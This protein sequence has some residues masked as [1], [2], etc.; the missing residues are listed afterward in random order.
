MKKMNA[1]RILALLLTLAMLVA[2]AACSGNSGSGTPTTTTTTDSSQQSS[3]TS[4]TTDT[5]PVVE[6]TEPEAPPRDLGG[7]NIRLSDWWT[8][9]DAEETPATTLRDELTREYRKSIQETHNFT[10][11]QMS[12]GGWGEYEELFMTSVMAGDP[13]AELFIMGPGFAAQPLAKGLFYPLSDLDALD[14]DNPKWNQMV[15][16]NLTLNG[17]VYGMTAT[18]HLEPKDFVFFNKRMLAEAGIDPDE[19]YDLQ[20][21]GEWTWDKFLEYCQKLTRD[22]DGDGVIDT[23]AIK[24][25]DQ[26]FIDGLVFSNNGR[27]VTK[28]ENGLFK[29]VSMEPNVLEAMQFFRKIHTEGYVTPSPEGA[30]WD[31]FVTAFHDGHAAMI[32]REWYSTG[33]WADMEDDWG[34]VFVPKGPNAPNNDYNNYFLE[35]IIVIPTGF[36]KEKAEDIAFA[37]NLWTDPIP[38]LDDDPEAWKDDQYPRFR[39]TRAVDETL[40]MLY[41]GRGELSLH[42]FIYG[43]DMGP[44]L[45]WVMANDDATPAEKLEATQAKWDAAVANAN[46]TFS[47]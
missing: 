45:H 31:W 17:K 15:I 22:T 16:E 34:M 8:N 10:L 26:E 43:M 13:L 42:Q 5:P 20:L 21:S 46:A 12:I 24:A 1:K 25:F 32:I 3:D 39:D 6:E 27:Y 23:Y 44:D 47:K 35:N 33:T 29:N 28:D 11:K 7:L 30:N 37:Y 18:Q 36:S 38:G 40:A 4:Q 9:N 2:L 14:F 41:E 19:P